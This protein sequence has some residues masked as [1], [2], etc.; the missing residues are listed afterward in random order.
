MK[1]GARTDNYEFCYEHAKENVKV[2]LLTKLIP[3]A[4]PLPSFC[5]RALFKASSSLRM[6]I[7][8]LR[9]RD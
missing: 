3:V 9:L 2:S 4:T 6:I 8:P 1:D 7:L 5:T